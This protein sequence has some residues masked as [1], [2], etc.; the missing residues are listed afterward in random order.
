M[1]PKRKYAGTSSGFRKRI[2]PWASRLS[3]SYIPRNIGKN[4]TYRNQIT[5]VCRSA[6]LDLELKGSDN[7]FSGG[8]G[9]TINTVRRDLLAGVS[10]TGLSGASEMVAL[11]DLI[12]LK[13]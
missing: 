7:G 5:T 8:F 2:R 4:S 6:T 11:F 1:A 12:R 9:F 13:K 3:K 10:F